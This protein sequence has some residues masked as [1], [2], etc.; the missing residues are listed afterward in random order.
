MSFIRLNGINKS[1]N[2]EKTQ[3]NALSDISFE[4]DRG[5]F[6]VV[7]GASGAGK[8]TLLSLIG[9]MEKADSGEIK[10]GASVIGDMSDGELVEYRRNGIGFAFENANLVDEMTAQ[11]NIELASSVCKNC[12]SAQKMMRTFG[13]E[14][15][16]DLLVRQLSDSEKRRLAIAAALGKNPPILLLD[17]PMRELGEKTSKQVLSL[18]HSACRATRMTVIVSTENPLLAS[19]ADRAITLDEGRILSVKQNK[20]AVG[21]EKL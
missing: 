14:D 12:F 21:I 8:T 16:K 1:Y 7:V 5:E 18:V 17:E 6:V 3:V 20:V 11:E 19:A 2:A 10:V 15:K 13:L 4:I 9:A